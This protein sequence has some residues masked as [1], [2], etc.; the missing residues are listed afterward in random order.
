MREEF[1]TAIESGQGSFGLKLT[2]DQVSRLAD[3]YQ[4]VMEDNDLLHLVA[5]CSAEE[6]A[7]RHVLESLTMLDHLPPNARFAD[8]GPGAGF[9]A[10]P[11]LLVRNDLSATLIESKE[12]KANYLAA[13]SE[14]LGIESRVSIVNRQ[15]EEA[16]PENVDVVT[17]RALDKFTQKLPKLVKWSKGRKMLLFG[18][19]GLRE[20]LEKTGRK[21]SQHLMPM[22][23]QRFLFVI[24][25]Q[26][27]SR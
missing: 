7:V 14:S 13:A 2:A 18:G 10:F 19:P 17:C 16:D 9:P 25:K 1:I 5:P 23:D 15:F 21:F 4:T 22:S 8:V 11:C 24:E 26:K 27:V 3:L 20:A 12:K 6:F